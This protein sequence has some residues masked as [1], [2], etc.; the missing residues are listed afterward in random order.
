[1]FLLYISIQNCGTENV[2]HRTQFIILYLK[3]SESLKVKVMV[4]VL[5]NSKGHILIDTQ[6][7]KL[8]ELNPDTLKSNLLTGRPLRASL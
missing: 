2:R 4:Y 5:F 6:N 3:L 8:W 1:M 7:G